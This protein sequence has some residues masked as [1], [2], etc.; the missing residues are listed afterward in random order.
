M[1]NW[2]M[3]EE[4]DHQPWASGRRDYPPF[5]TPVSSRCVAVLASW[6]IITFHTE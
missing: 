6:F 3:A 4:S 1:M 2:L 5:D